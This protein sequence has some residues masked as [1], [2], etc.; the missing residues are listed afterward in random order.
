MR[1]FNE[2]LF[3]TD[4][5]S[6]NE[7]T[8]NKLKRKLENSQPNAKN[9][10]NR[11]IEEGKV[12]NDVVAPIGRNLRHQRETPFITFDANGE[13]TMR[14]DEE[15][16]SRN[17]IEL[18]H[19]WFK[20]HEN[21]ITQIGEKFGV[22]GGYLKTIAKSN[23]PW[24]RDLSAEI[25]NK[26]SYN[27]DRQRVL[28]RAVGDQVRG[29]LSDHYKRYDA[30]DIVGAFLAQVQNNHGTLVDGYMSDTRIW[31][32]AIHPEP[33]IV[34][35]QKNGDI[36][37]VFGARLSTSD[38]GNGAL[39]LRSHL[40][41]V[42]CL[43]QMVRESQL[44]RVHLGSRL[45]D[46]IQLSQRTY[47]KDTETMASAITDIT[48]NIFDEANIREQAIAIQRSSEK[49][50]DMDKQLKNLTRGKITKG[51]AEQVQKVLNRSNPEDGLYG[52]GTLWKL[53]NALTAYARDVEPE[54]KRELQEVAGSLIK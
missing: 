2:G 10:M 11:L 35:T 19:Q 7:A 23:E 40:M 29:V 28:V 43:N 36:V 54:R 18:P 33:V 42:T 6:L 44:K 12:Q 37:L 22:P 52:E 21:A 17:Q 24:A 30:K 26:H 31:F 14:M 49:E 13:L 50:V 47:R 32:E 45:P 16:L 4:T 25:L 3:T 39:E 46:N 15:I 34:P 1:T 20:L 9:A 38:Y 5:A 27:T 53:G 41:Q 51:E 48:G 8:M